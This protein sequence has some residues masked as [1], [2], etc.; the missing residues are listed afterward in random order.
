MPGDKPLYEPMMVSL[1]MYIGIIRPKWFNGKNVVYW[2]DGSNSTHWGGDKMADI[3]QTKLPDVFSWMKMFEVRLQFDW[4]LCLWIQFTN[5]CTALIPIMSWHQAGNKSLPEPMQ[6]ATFPIDWGP[7]LSKNW[8]G[9]GKLSN[10]LARRS[11][12]ISSVL[13]YDSISGL[14]VCTVGLWWIIFTLDQWSMASANTISHTANDE[15]GWWRIYASLSLNELRHV[16]WYETDKFP[17]GLAIFNDFLIVLFQRVYLSL[18]HCN[19]D[20]FC[21]NWL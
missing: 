13:L 7:D 5:T 4:S 14:Y 11:M 2:F 8:V 1:L 9:L 6:C 15:Q 19:P 18:I 20:S 21:N 17:G 3:F 16:P 12:V 10:L